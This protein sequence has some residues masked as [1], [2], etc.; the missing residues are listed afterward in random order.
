MFEYVGN[1]RGIEWAACRMKRQSTF[2]FIAIA[3]GK[4]L[5]AGFPV[6]PE[7]RRAVNF[8]HFAFFNKLKAMFQHI[9]TPVFRKD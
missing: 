1:A 5:R 2:V 3:D 6:A 4:Q 8:R 7:A 9:I